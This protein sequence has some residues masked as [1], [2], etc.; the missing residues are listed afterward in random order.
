MSV[1][2]SDLPGSGPRDGRA[3][4]DETPAEQR[5]VFDPATNSWTGQPVCITP[6]VGE[7]LPEMTERLTVRCSSAGRERLRTFVEAS[8][9]RNQTQ[10]MRAA[11]REFLDRRDELASDDV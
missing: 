7:E 4:V 2:E 6:V 3:T 5:P 1:E 10:V 8:E 11:L 9:Y